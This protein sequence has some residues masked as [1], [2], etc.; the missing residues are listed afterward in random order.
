MTGD[1]CT[2]LRAVI[3]L[4]LSGRKERPQAGPRAAQTPDNRH[5]SRLL[6]T[7][8]VWRLCT[9]WYVYWFSYP[10]TTR[11]VSVVPSQGAC[12]PV[13]AVVV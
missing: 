11:L 3:A 13:A 8:L 5:H 12:L 1:N 2:E 4:H 6:S 9:L 7:M 10:S